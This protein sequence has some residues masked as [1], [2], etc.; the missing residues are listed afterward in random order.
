MKTRPHPTFEF[1]TLVDLTKRFH[2]GIQ[3]VR[4]CSRQA[5]VRL[6]YVVLR[7]RRPLS[8]PLGR[9]LPACYA[10]LDSPGRGGTALH[11][12]WT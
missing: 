5:F 6:A 8:T 11:L 3:G 10:R 7:L 2:P 1:R 4:A 9:R 12:H